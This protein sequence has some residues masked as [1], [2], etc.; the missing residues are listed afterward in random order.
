MSDTLGEVSICNS[1]L[2]KVGGARIIALSDDSVEGRVCNEQYVKIRDEMLSGHP[3]NFA[4]Q[5]AVLASSTTAPV[6][7]YTYAY[8]LP[9]DC[10]RV[11]SME[12]DTDFPWQV[13]SGILLTDN[14]TANVLYVKREV[15]TGRYSATFREAL[16]TQLAADISYALT[17]N[18]A[19]KD[20]L[21]KDADMKLR[22]ARSFNGQESNGNRVYADSWLN[23]RN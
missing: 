7:E 1:A 9:F 12:L 5:R 21:Q 20:R 3:W 4:K 2:S 23:S 17:Q 11:L 22:L 19:L 18:A 8:P 10:L 13:E 14:G 6:Y 15:L 16:A